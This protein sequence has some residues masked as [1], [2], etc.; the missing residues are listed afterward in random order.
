[1]ALPDCVIAVDLPFDLHFQHSIPRYAPFTSFGCVLG[2]IRPSPPFVRTVYYTDAQ[3]DTAAHIVPVFPRL[4]L[5]A[6][7]TIPPFTLYVVAQ[8]H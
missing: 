1:M 8:H 4:S 3:L 5:R 6:R 2:Y 7:T